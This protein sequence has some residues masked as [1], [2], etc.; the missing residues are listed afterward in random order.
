MFFIFDCLSANHLKGKK[1][2]LSIIVVSIAIDWYIE[3]GVGTQN[4]TKRLAKRMRM[5][6]SISWQSFMT[7]RYTIQR[8]DTKRYSVSCATL[9]EVF[10]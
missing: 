7:K 2:T 3:Q 1:S 6:V 5:T 10:F 4:H 8:M 9:N